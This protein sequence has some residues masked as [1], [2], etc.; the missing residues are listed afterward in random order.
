[1]NP[2]K[3]AMNDNPWPEKDLADWEFEQAEEDY[4]QEDMLDEE[5]V[6]LKDRLIKEE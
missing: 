1:M 5:E 6:K 3:D 4:L 2:L